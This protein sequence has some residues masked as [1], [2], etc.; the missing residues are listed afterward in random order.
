V[1]VLIHGGFWSDRYGAD[2]MEPVAADLRRRG[3]A[4][5]NVEYRRLGSG[6]GFP[7]TFADV[8]AAV[9]HVPDLGFGAVPVAVVGH[10]SGGHLAAWAAA[11]TAATP[12]GVPRVTAQVTISLSGVL[13]LAAAGL[14]GVGGTA[15]PALIGSP[16]D[17]GA[18]DYDLAD[19]VR[20]VP[21]RGRLVAVHAEDDD[22]VPVEQSQDFVV[23]DVHAGADADLVAVPGGHFALIDPTT[24]AWH[25]SAAE[26]AR[27]V[28]PDGR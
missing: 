26:L 9:D 23:T 13:C 22:L 7:T 8:A 4:T 11:R 10:S 21:T 1:V 12:G 19:P 28:G 14:A 18:S 16:F 3:Y 27:V 2:L 15:V 24:S 17:G 20:L 6:G 25:R 5:W